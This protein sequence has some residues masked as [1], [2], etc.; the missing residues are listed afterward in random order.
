MKHF[1]ERWTGRLPKHTC[2]WRT[3]IG[4]D[5]PLGLRAGVRS[6]CRALGLSKPRGGCA[7][8]PSQ[9]SPAVAQVGGGG[10]SHVQ[11]TCVLHSLWSRIWSEPEW[12]ELSPQQMPRFGRLC[13]Y[14]GSSALWTRGLKSLLNYITRGIISSSF[15]IKPGQLHTS[16]IKSV[17]FMWSVLLSLL[18]VS[19]SILLSVFISLVFPNF[20]LFLLLLVALVSCS[21]TFHS[22]LLFRPVASHCNPQENLS[23]RHQIIARQRLLPAFFFFFCSLS[24]RVVLMWRNPTWICLNLDVVHQKLFDVVA[25]FPRPNLMHPF[26]LGNNFKRIQSK[27]VQTAEVE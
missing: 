16:V 7:G 14:I 15:L 17:L 24:P 19:R 21:C 2:R 23:T 4:G 20:P 13:L 1:W 22:L 11:C 9:T 26:F 8:S 27:F 5:V 18:A 6:G 25:A 3:R 10:G 12:N